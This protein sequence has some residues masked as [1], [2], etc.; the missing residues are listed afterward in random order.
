MD[1]ITNR[2]NRSKAV[3]QANENARI[4]GFEP[5]QQDLENQ[6]Q[7]VEGVLS[8]EDLLNIA[9]QKACDSHEAQS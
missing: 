5:D 2:E 1:N 8:I 4:E 7:F 9:T 3:R 6:Q